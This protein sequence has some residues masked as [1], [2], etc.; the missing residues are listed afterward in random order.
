MLGQH[1]GQR[2]V[3]VLELRVVGVVGLEEPELL[4]LQVGG[5]YGRQNT[6]LLPGIVFLKTPAQLRRGLRLRLGE[7]GEMA[8]PDLVFGF[9]CQGNA[10]PCNRDTTCKGHRTRQGVRDQDGGLPVEA[11]PGAAAQP[12]HQGLRLA[13]LLAGRRAGGLAG[14]PASFGLGGGGPPLRLMPL[15]LSAL[16]ED[17]VAAGPG[18]EDVLQN[19]GR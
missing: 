9:G 7:R 8:P 4:P 1:A 13:K 16:E 3:R 19:P 14:L 2:G 6:Q 10:V 17:I 18:G 5:L 15:L 12:R 11:A